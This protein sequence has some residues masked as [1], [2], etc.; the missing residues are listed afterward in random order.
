MTLFDKVLAAWMQMIHCVLA[1]QVGPLVNNNRDQRQ[2]DQHYKSIGRAYSLRWSADYPQNKHTP[3]R[4]PI[5]LFSSHLG[6]L[7]CLMKTCPYLCSGKVVSQGPICEFDWINRVFSIEQ[8]APHA[9]IRTNTHVHFFFALVKQDQFFSS[10]SHHLEQK[11][12]CRNTRLG[13]LLFFFALPYS[14]ILWT[15]SAPMCFA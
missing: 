11:W 1:G 4:P 15:T 9:G 14:L 5:L 2:T 6:R 13:C 10:T 7:L 12:S 3:T 8:H